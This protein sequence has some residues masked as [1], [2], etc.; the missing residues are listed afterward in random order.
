MTIRNN[1]YFLRFS[2]KKRYFCFFN[3]ND[4]YYTLEMRVIVIILLI[5]CFIVVLMNSTNFIAE[6]VMKKVK[7]QDYEYEEPDFQQPFI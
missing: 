2:L 1:T 3:F 5:L 7:L 6:I 4:D